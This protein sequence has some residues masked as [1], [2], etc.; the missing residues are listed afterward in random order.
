MCLGLELATQFQNECIETFSTSW[1]IT[2]NDNELSM[3]FD[4]VVD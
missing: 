2:L 3:S 1:W 4:F